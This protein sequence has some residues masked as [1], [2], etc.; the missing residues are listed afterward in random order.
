[1]ICENCGTDINRRESYCPNCGM[2]LMVPYSKSLKE[3]YIAGE[4]YDRQERYNTDANR[5]Q[6]ESEA[7]YPAESTAEGYQVENASQEVYETEES[8]TS[9]VL[10][11]FLFLI[12]ALLVG[13]IFGFAVFSGIL[14][15]LPGFSNIGF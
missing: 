8:G 5:S 3:K 2:E 4:Y 14:H 12:I 9:L 11:L 6:R 10:V 1:M 15:S 7:D 13:F